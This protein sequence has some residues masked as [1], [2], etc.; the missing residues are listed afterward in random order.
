M[1][2]KTKNLGLPVIEYP[3]Q[4]VCLSVS[5][6]LTVSNNSGRHVVLGSLFISCI[7]C[8]VIF[9]LVAVVINMYF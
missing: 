5:P 8:S 3:D 9:G 4:P 1:M 6:I 7:F 2:R